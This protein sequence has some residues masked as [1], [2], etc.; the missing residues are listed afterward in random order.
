MDGSAVGGL[1]ANG[2]GYNNLL[3]MAVILEHL[4]EPGLDESPLFL[5]EEPE[6]HLHPQLTLLLADYLS[7]KTPGSKTPQT[8]VTTHSPT[9][10]AAVPPS[11]ISVLFSKP[12]SREV[13]CHGLCKAA[14]SD[15]EQRELRRMMDITRA[16]LYFAKGVILVEGISEALLIPALALR[17]GHDLSKLHISVIPICGVDFETF[18]KI[19]DPTVLGTPVSIVTDA[20][21]EVPTDLAWQDALPKS[22]N[23]EFCKSDRTKKVLELFGGRENIK[24][25]CSQVTL[26]YD[27]AE[28]GE[29]NALTMAEVWESC[30]VGKP[31]T[32]NKA[33]VLQG[34]GSRK[35]RALTAWRGIC[36][37]SHTGS[38]ADFAHRLTEALSANQ[39]ENSTF[40]NFQVPSYLRDAIEHV[41]KSATPA[42]LGTTPNENPLDGTTI[43]A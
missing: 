6:A 40:A 26:E 23:G 20:D 11:R 35:E 28:A 9:L 7:N 14:M 17:L 10:A 16:T 19:L 5:I 38:K 12:D 1:D 24:V 42:S 29:A 43:S 15:K 37:A 18:H 25:C 39:G 21:P 22:E 4:K 33:A 2:L 31:G 32:F 3:Y 8:I 30:F 13:F 27:L 34:G 36:R 41:V